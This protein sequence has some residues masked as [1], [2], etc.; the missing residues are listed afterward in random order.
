MLGFNLSQRLEISR[1][2]KDSTSKDLT[3]VKDVFD[4]D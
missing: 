2:P 1:H 4:D 3:L